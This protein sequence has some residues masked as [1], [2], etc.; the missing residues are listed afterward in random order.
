MLVKDEEEQ[1]PTT[2]AAVL[3]LGRS[4]VQNTKSSEDTHELSA[5]PVPII[6]MVGT[7]RT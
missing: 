5:L 2:G 7:E 6:Q 1:L 4:R 3:T